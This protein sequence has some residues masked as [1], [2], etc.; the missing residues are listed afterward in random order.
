MSSQIPNSDSLL[1]AILG[2]NFNSKLSNKLCDLSRKLPE[3]YADFSK[4]IMVVA[5]ELDNP[6]YRDQSKVTNKDN[7]TLQKSI[8]GTL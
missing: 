1:N 3:R 4:R 6:E 2:V 5:E 8:A 7:K